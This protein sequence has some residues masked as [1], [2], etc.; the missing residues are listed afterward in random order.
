M[1]ER[2]PHSEAE[3]IFWC[4]VLIVMVLLG[5]LGLLAAKKLRRALPP[6]PGFEL[7]ELERM[8]VEG[9]IST[10]EAKQIKK[11]IVTRIHPQASPESPKSPEEPDDSSR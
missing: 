11:A 3:V 1:P 10:D 8:K 9:F 5:Y 6:S 4:G 2:A 7:S